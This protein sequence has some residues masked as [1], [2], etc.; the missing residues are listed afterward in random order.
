MKTEISF[1][2]PSQIETEC[3]VAVVLDCSANG[4]PNPA[5]ETSD[6]AVTAAAADLLASGEVTGKIFEAT[7][8]HRPQGLKARRLLLV[9]GGK[10]A[11]FS[12]YELRRLTGTAARFLKPRSIRSFAFLSPERLGSGGPADAVKAVVEGAFVGN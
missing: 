9:G 12:G 7:M 10:A 8:V 4:K 3:L 6:Q 5:L 1:A 2:A 11:N